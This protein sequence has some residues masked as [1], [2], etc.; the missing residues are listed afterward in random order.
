MA[1]DVFRCVGANVTITH[2]LKKGLQIHLDILWFCLN[3]QEKISDPHVYIAQV[4]P[5]LN[6]A[7]KHLF[8]NDPIFNMILH[9]LD[10]QGHIYS[11]LLVDRNRN[12]KPSDFP[13]SSTERSWVSNI[14]FPM[15]HNCLSVKNFQHIILTIIIQDCFTPNASTS[16]L[17]K[18]C[19]LAN[20]WCDYSFC[21]SVLTLWKTNTEIRGIKCI[22]KAWISL[23]S[24]A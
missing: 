12:H 1:L 9:A 3:W 21:E 14:L 22:Q 4:H 15:R 20:F 8:V 24:M 19:Q 16:L 10:P 17:G 5:R 18:H 23:V 11:Y 6:N 7:K 2:H 13:L